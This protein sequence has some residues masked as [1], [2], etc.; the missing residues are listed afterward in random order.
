MF[1]IDEVYNQQRLNDI[2]MAGNK[3]VLTH[4]GLDVGEDG[5]THQCIDYVGLLNN[6]FG[7]KLVVPADPNQTD[8]AT[9]WMLR[10]PGDICMAV[11]RSKIDGLKEFAGD[12]EFKYG[13]AVKLRDGKDGSIFALGYM[14]QL[15]LQAAEAHNLNVSVYAV[16]SPLAPDMNALKEAAALGPILTVED[17][18]ANTGMGAVMLLEAV[19]QGIALPKVKTLGVTHYGA[20]ATSDKVREEM[21]LSP[22]AIAKAFEALRG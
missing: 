5:K 21:G 2:N 8:R 7:W 3:T 17:H 14:A 19:R 16:S 15:A 12:Y 4:V 6:T 18:N 1:G 22:E 9:R 13:E 10:T 20:S 11:G